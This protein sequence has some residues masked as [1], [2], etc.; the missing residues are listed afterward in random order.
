MQTT[1]TTSTESAIWGRVLSPAGST[2]SPEAARAVL[3][4]DFPPAD[5][6]RMRKLAAKARREKLS[7]REQDEI[8]SYGRIGSFL[9]ILKSR[10]RVALRRVQGNGSRT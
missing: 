2:L 8:D 1:P 6:E 9:S 3:Q 5:K 10:A 7:P 4:I